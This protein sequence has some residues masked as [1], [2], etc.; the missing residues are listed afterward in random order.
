[1]LAGLATLAVVWMWAREAM[2]RALA[3]VALALAVLSVLL[4]DDARDARMYAI[5]A[6]FATASWWLT[7][8]LV[9]LGPPERAIRRGTVL[10]ATALAIAVAGEAVDA[11]ARTAERGSADGLRLRG[12]GGSRQGDA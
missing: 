11:G 1:M 2:G 5:E 10:T 7:W 3:G 4:I 9:A 6:A 8:R 12:R